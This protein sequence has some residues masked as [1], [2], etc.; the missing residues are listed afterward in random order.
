MTKPEDQKAHLPSIRFPN[1]AEQGHAVKVSGF[2][3]ARDVGVQALASQPLT[4]SF[5]LFSSA[6]IV[7]FLFFQSVFH[8]LKP[9]ILNDKHPY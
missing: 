1:S 6:A 3:A 7:E 5:F 2:R 4:C 9:Y 8:A